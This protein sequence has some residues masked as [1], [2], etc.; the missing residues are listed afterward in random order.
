MRHLLSSTHDDC[1]DVSESRQQ[2]QH[3]TLKRN[4]RCSGMYLHLRTSSGSSLLAAAE[5][6][7]SEVGNR[8][9]WRPAR[10]YRLRA[11]RPAPHTENL[12]LH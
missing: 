2:Q 11:H 3:F 4:F 8:V 5:G 1:T 12:K 10:T 7:G 6:K 9:S